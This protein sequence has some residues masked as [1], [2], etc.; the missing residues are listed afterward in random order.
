MKNISDCLFIALFI[1]STAGGARAQDAPGRKTNDKPAYLDTSLTFE[2]RAADLVS[3][4]TLDEKISQMQNGAPAIPRLGVDKYNWWS[5]CLHG[6]ARNGIA[7]VFPQ[8][9]GMA[10]TW[11]DALIHS[12]ADVIS[13]EARAKHNDDV[14]KGERNIYQGLTFWSPNVNIFRDPRWGRGQETYGED[15]YLTLRTGVAFVKGLQGDDPKYFKVISTPKHYAVHSGPE[16]LRHEFD[17]VVSN[18]DLFE[19]YLPA[20]RACV[21]EGGAFS[22]M[23]AYSA[24]DGTPCCASKFLLTKVLR[25]KWGFKGYVVSDCGAIENIY[26]GH[27]YA[28]D[29]ASASALAVKAGCD[30]TCGGEFVTLK[31]AAARGLVSE[32]EIDRSV[33][34]LMLARFKLGMFDP[35]DA[36]PYNK[37]TI[38]DNDTEPHRQLARKVA[39]E[40][41]V[42]LKNAGN[43]LPLKKN[44]KSVA[45]IGA[46]ADDIAILLGN[47]EGTPSRPV[48]LLRGIKNK[49]GSTSDVEFA[50]GYRALEDT[51][52]VGPTNEELIKSA[53]DVSRKSDVAI[54]V[55]GISPYLEGEEMNID[56]PGFKG[57]DRTSLNIP[58]V[59]EDLI[60]AVYAT[61]KPVVLVLVGG[62]ALAVNWEDKNL[63]AIVDAWYPGEEGGNAVANVL[64]GDYNPAGRL[65]ITFYK[66]VKDIPP[67]EDYNMSPGRDTL[68]E[69]GRTYRYYTGTPLYPFG[70]GLS[71]T[72]FDYSNF[73]LSSNSA[74]PSDTLAVSLTLQNTGQYDGDE[75]VE[76]YVRSLTHSKPQPIKSLEGFKRVELAK[77]QSKVVNLNLPVSSLEYFD[78]QKEDYVVEPGKYEI[79]VGSSSSDIRLRAV[80]N[81]Q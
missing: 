18:R 5:E 70:F 39:D 15:P 14:L 16:P 69:P 75:V 11:D 78:D 58:P 22:V 24:L 6:V 23:G 62:S 34:R 25:D 40:S 12:E 9:I 51:V 71:Y 77:G 52:S 46:Y 2:A 28:P 20:F 37:I 79:Q 65:P 53:V 74:S 55:A 47:Y 44:L 8:A 29:L 60:K 50:A 66:S 10:A 1:L 59:E 76:L 19:T 4:M 7:T 73:R 48:T 35:P 38:S 41:I 43:F 57:G 13:T 63:P 21:T 33:E 42:L 67:F 32:K 45:V 31:D 64:F 49:I 36:V 54:I 27:K 30:L 68:T 80:L 72:K 81:V 61:G 26:G 56:I 3:Q 17:A